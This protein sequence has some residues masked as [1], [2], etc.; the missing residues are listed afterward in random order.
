MRNFVWTCVC[1]ALRVVERSAHRRLAQSV[2]LLFQTAK[3]NVIPSHCL[4]IFP[5]QSKTTGGWILNVPYLAHFAVVFCF[6]IVLGCELEVIPAALAA[7]L[8][9]EVKIGLVTTIC[10]GCLYPCVHS[11]YR[12]P[13]TTC[14]DLHWHLVVRVFLLMGTQAHIMFVKQMVVVISYSLS[15]E[16]VHLNEAFHN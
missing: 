10:W 15:A 14:K 11:V 6:L 13:N 5:H 3:Q 16:P 1:A 4:H 2:C 7:S 8:L 9:T 12:I